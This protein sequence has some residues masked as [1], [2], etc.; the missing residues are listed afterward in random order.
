MVKKIKVNWGGKIRD[1]WIALGN[2]GYALGNWKIMRIKE[3]RNIKEQSNHFLTKESV[4]VIVTK[5]HEPIF[6]LC[7]GYFIN[8]LRQKLNTLH[9]WDWKR[10]Q[11]IKHISEKIRATNWEELDKNSQ[12]R[13]IK[14]II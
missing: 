3:I 14:H 5:F 2:E 10:K 7:W 13:K 12:N 11:W 6:K 4:W 1:C 9:F 8:A